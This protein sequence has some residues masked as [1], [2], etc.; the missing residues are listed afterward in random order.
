MTV[1]ELIERLRSYPQDAEVLVKND[2]LYFNGLY[3]A[4]DVEDYGN[5]AVIISTDY[6]EIVD[7]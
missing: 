4:T 7:D 1:S 2:D 3:F 6:D 5:E